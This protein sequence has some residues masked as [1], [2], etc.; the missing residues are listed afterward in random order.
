MTRIRPCAYAVGLLVF[1]TTSAAAQFSAAP[2]EA[3]DTALAIR[4][5]TVEARLAPRAASNWTANEILNVSQCDQSGPPWV[6]MLWAAY[7]GIAMSLPDL[8]LGSRSLGDARLMTTLIGVA[9]DAGRPSELRRVALDVLVGY[10]IPSVSATPITVPD[11]ASLSRLLMGDAPDLYSGPMPLPPN[12]EPTVHTLVSSLSSSD[13]DAAVRDYSL[14]LL[15]ALDEERWFN[16]RPVVD[17]TKITLSYA[18]GNRFSIRNG[19]PMALVMSFDVIGPTAADSGQAAAEVQVGER[20]PPAAFAES[21]FDSRMKGTV[22]LSLN[23]T[24]IR[25]KPNGNTKCAW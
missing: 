7:P 22:R 15:A 17:K 21:F 2:S 20:R 9:Q 13:I 8:R 4:C 10:A 18:C 23:N 12:L 1:A 16:G 24:V 19:N 3:V 11:S 5:A 6:A 14:R 25:V